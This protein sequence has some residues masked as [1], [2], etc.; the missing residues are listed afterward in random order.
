MLNYKRFDR[1]SIS[2]VSPH[3]PQTAELAVTKGE[4]QRSPRMNG[5]SRWS[6]IIFSTPP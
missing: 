4:Q 5:T 3:L 1:C 2:P 6:P